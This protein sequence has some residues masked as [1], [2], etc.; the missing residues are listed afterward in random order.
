MTSRQHRGAE[1]A[2]SSSV[3]QLV[4]DL[5][6]KHSSEAVSSRPRKSRLVAIPR[7]QRGPAK[8]KLARPRH[9]A[10]SVEHATPRLRGLYRKH[11]LIFPPYTAST[12]SSEPTFEPPETQWRK[13][14]S[15]LQFLT[16]PTADTPGT[17]L[18]LHFDNKR[19]IIGSLAE[20]TQ[21]ASVQQ[22]ARLLKVSDIF[23]TGKTQWSNVGGLIGMILTLADAA[24]SS[25]ATSAEDIRKKLY[26]KA[27]HG[28]GST[29]TDD[30]IETTF[31]DQ[32][33][34][35]VKDKARLHI[36]G[37]P[38][39][40]Y[41][42]ATARRFVFRK[43]MPVDVRE[44]SASGEAAPDSAPT[45]SDANINVWAIPLLPASSSPNQH[46]RTSGSISPRKRSHDE[47]DGRLTESSETPTDQEKTNMMAKSVVSEMFDST[48]RLDALVE[49]PINE[50]KLPAT[51][52]V[53]DQ[54]T[55]KTVKYTGPMPGGP[56]PVPNIKVMVRRPWPGAL[57]ETLPPTEPAQEALSYIIKNHYQRGKFRPQLAVQLQVE[58]GPKWSLLT[59]GKSVENANGETI[60]PDMVLDEGKEGGGVAVIDLP[61]R[62]YVEALVQRP[63]WKND[64]IMSGIGAFIWMLGPGVAE[65][66][67]L[68]QFMTEMNQMQHV[69]ASPDTC[70][71]RLSLDSSAA[72]TMRLKHVDPAR[73]GVPVHQNTPT[74]QRNQSTEAGHA[75]TNNSPSL[76]AE[77]GMMIQLEPSVEVQDKQNTPLVDLEAVSAAMSPDVLQV[78][79]EAQ[80]NI[81][82]SKQDLKAWADK[83]PQKD[84][85]IIALGTGSALP[86]KYRNV[87]ATLMRVPGWGS[88]L[89]DCGENTLGQLKRVYTEDEL[90]DVL[91]D[92]RVIWISHMHADHHLGT[93]SVI[94]EWY[95]TVHGSIPVPVPSAT[96]PSFSPIPLFL[97]QQRLSVI[98]DVPMLHWMH[99]YSTVE[100][101]GF[102]R[103]AP[104]SISPARLGSNTPSDLTWFVPPAA[105]QH[106]TAEARQ[107]WNTNVA[108]AFVPASV[109]GFADIQAVLVQHCHGA[110][111]VSMTFPSGF[112]ASYSGDCRPSRAF[113]QIGKGSTVCI[114]E[115]TFDD[116]LQ[117]DAE[118]KNHTTT[119]EALGV[120]LAMDSKACVLTHFSQRYQKVPVL[121]YTDEDDGVPLIDAATDDP[122]AAVDDGA[123]A[124]MTD[125]AQAASGTAGPIQPDEAKH[126][127]IKLKRGTD[128]KVC[129][130][131]DLMRIK[132]GDIAQMEKLTPALVRLFATEEKEEVKPQQT[133]ES[134][135]GEPQAAG[136][137]KKKV[138]KSKRNN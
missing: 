71:N 80:K 107:T 135:R 20:G 41:L 63:E 78:A 15:Y 69:I 136:N 6:T 58:K 61:S 23:I 48:W 87:S 32:I 72:A 67:S 44:Y 90:A 49:T 86:S 46:A 29:A 38:N 66:P 60:T 112:K 43:G 128:M 84:V 77:R 55:G 104:M 83:L 97:N 28:S 137:K 68:G 113:A 125:S 94:R 4:T 85:E 35:E 133:S 10:S 33:A 117:G 14:R 2:P 11:H 19:Y 12:T 129:V 81:L 120:A 119:S 75:A 24:S 118:A 73:Y 31:A 131:F 16:T 5:L 121:E 52:F 54:V 103:L 127:T 74:I 99:E 13:M 89:L 93:V 134:V 124:P 51:L 50:V 114:H 42:L 30:F 36:F 3:P 47:L 122:E 40:N 18:L 95:R 17:T 34:R 9:Q 130:A 53:R 1:D 91:R 76:C 98:S 96:S 138:K 57:I 123:E 82:D 110:R 45:W 126:T 21:R 56:L 79:A 115:A 27:G 39:L 8:E 37:A 59:Q 7:T 106:S 108:R 65:C 70:P 102:S 116:E 26:V 88:V 100:D 22:S 109:V 62:A 105:T 64:Q 132:V 101:Y 92:L 111:A 25:A